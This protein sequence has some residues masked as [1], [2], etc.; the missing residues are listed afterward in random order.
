MQSSGLNPFSRN[1]AVWLVLGLLLVL[2]FQAFGR[3]DP[4]LP[5]LDYSEFS[6]ALERSEVARV[7]IQ[8]QRVEGELRNGEHFVTYDPGDDDMVSR[9]RE[10]DVRIQ[11]KPEDGEP[12]YLVL[13]VQWFPMSN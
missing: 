7:T 13:L 8:G 12:W 2:V 6:D 1:L 11:A 10:R 9:L 3:P 5:E 4:V